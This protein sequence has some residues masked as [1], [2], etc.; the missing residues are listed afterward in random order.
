M[1]FNGF[2]EFLGYSAILDIIEYIIPVLGFIGIAVYFWWDDLMSVIKGNNK[3][4]KYGDELV[5]NL[6]KDTKS[7]FDD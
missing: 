7:I 6:P 2:L 4:S 1:S 5:K 3:A